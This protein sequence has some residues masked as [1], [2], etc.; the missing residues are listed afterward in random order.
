M[1][2]S[3]PAVSVVIPTYNW[4]AALRCAIRS[5]LLQTMQDF[6]V[7]VVGDGCTDDSAEVVASFG[8]ARIRWFNLDR[9]YG[10]QWAANNFANEHASGDW[11]AYLGHDDIW[12]P[13][14]LQAVLAAAEREQAHVVT[15]TMIL[16]WPEPTGGRSLAGVF[17]TGVYT[18]S[19]FVPPSALAHRRDLYGTVVHWRDPDTVALPMDAQFINEL[20]VADH[21]FAQTHELT[22]F[23]YNA[24]WRRDAYK[25]KSTA[26]QERMLARIESGAD[27][28]QGELLDVLKSVVAGRFSPIA[29]PPTAGIEPGWGVRN[30][31]RLKG[32]DSRHDPSRLTRIEQATR[33]DMSGQTMPFEWHS[34]EA[35]AEHGLFRW[36]GP[37]PRATIDLPVIFDRDLVVRIHIVNT[38]RKDL[39]NRVTLAIHGHPLQVH[40]HNTGS[41]YVFEAEARCSEVG[42]S[43][44]DFGITID[45][46]AVHRPI[47]AGINDDTRWLGVA[48]NWVEVAP[49]T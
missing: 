23:K 10:S 49:L 12:Y 28:R 34:N 41:T 4:S 13:T 24:A 33:F 32:L 25:V 30:N 22:C 2:M 15:S 16:Y 6:E 9:N 40:I 44:R 35:S 27:F 14:H 47:D 7:L 1:A 5:V 18:E 39:I 26:E 48:V 8:D 43:E 20:L 38:L 42:N 11:I 46:G 3:K 17:A 36:T 19:D 45:V 31:R 21:R 29:A 37:S